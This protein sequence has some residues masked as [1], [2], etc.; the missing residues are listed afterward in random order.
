MTSM[1]LLHPSP[2][3]GVDGSCVARTRFAKVPLE[4]G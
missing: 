2:C 4:I 1:D 3:S